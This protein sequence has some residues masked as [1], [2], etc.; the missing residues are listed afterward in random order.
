MAKVSGSGSGGASR[1]SSGAST[2]SKAKTPTST[3]SS[4]PS[5]QPNGHQGLKD[6]ARVSQEAR[7]GKQSD[8]ARSDVEKRI[9]SLEEQFK[10]LQKANKEDKP[11]EQQDGGGGG[12]GEGGPSEAGEAD[13]AKEQFKQEEQQIVQ[14]ATQLLPKKNSFDLVTLT[15][16]SQL[17]QRC[18]ALSQGGMKPQQ[19]TRR[20]VQSV[21]G[22]DPFG[23]KR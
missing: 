12:G 3:P 9:Q 1:A 5:A 4:K 7:E 21:L 16:K 18:Q 6:A 8:K 15:Q 23:G 14:L 2:A 13:P 11:Q 20:L 19:S 22:T 10:E 17:S